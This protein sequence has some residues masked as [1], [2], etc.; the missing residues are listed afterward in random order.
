MEYQRDEFN[1]HETQA[2]HLRARTKASVAL[3]GLLATGAFD[4]I[5]HLGLAGAVIGTVLTGILVVE[6]PRI[7][8]KLQ[9]D[10]PELYAWIERRRG[11][12]Q[13]DEEE[14]SDDYPEEEIA[15]FLAD[16]QAAKEK[17]GEVEEENYNVVV[18]HLSETWTPSANSFLS[19]R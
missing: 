13:D 3:G 8:R 11:T 2:A 1:E 16:W 12:D 14:W 17:A 10:F 5:A 15:A 18:L 6:S 19:Q 4:G 7:V 9:Q